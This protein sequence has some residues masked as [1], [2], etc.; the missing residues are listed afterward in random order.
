MRATK[1]NKSEICKMAYKFINE[2]GMTQS[3]AMR[4]AWAVAKL[5]VRMKVSIVQFFYIKKSTGEIRQAFGTTDPNRYEYT[6]TGTGR[7]GNYADC[8][9]YWDTEKQ[10]FRM[11]K[12][13]NLVNVIA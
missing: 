1:Y 4:K 11:F 5:Q 2:Q 12:T 6:P 8:I 3:E 9:Q 10:G 13:Y 7:R